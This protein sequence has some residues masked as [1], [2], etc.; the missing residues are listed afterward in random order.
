MSVNS[1]FSSLN[2]FRPAR[3]SFGEVVSIKLVSIES[4]KDHESGIWRNLDNDLAWTK[5]KSIHVPASSNA[6]WNWMALRS[7][8]TRYC[9][10]SG[11]STVTTCYLQSRVKEV[12]M[13]I[14]R[15][16]LMATY[17]N[18]GRSIQYYTAFIRE[19]VSGQPI[20]GWVTGQ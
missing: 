12:V 2:D 17:H 18:Q 10:I 8:V 11:H 4:I 19:D 1:Y 6:Y 7:A 20:M 16:E 15:R 14:H 5:R 9:A 13:E 3:A